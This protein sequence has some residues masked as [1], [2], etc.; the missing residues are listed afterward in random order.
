M[1]KR[2]VKRV[3]ISTIYGGHAVK[4][5]ITKLSP[6]KLILLMDEPTDTKK[7]E[8]IIQVVKSI[9]EFF[10]DTLTIETRKILNYDIPKIMKEVI[11]IIDKESEKGNEILIHT[12]EGRKT[13][14]LALL[15]ASY[16][17]RG[18]IEGAYYITEEEHE[19]I[20]LPL[21]NFGINETKKMVLK[22]IEKGNGNLRE[23]MEK[24]KIKQSATYQNVQE[25]KHEGYVSNAGQLKLTD[26]GRVMVL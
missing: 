22:E 9:Q 10:K 17:R 13:A 11:E 8:D 24:L 19:L 4:Q 26:L 16:R 20:R 18:K 25:L 23:L 5:A 2:C 1:K 3:V 12:T 21:L 15:F 14:S 6:D 7:K